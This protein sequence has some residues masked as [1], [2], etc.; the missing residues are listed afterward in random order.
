MEN[1]ES[2]DLG[3]L[4]HIL[5]DRKKTVGKIVGG[6]T[7]L[8]LIVSFALPKTYES[9]T[10]VQAR[11]RGVGVTEASQ[12]MAAMGMG[13]AS[14][15]PVM[16]YMELM[17]SNTVLQP[18]IDELDW[19]EDK[20][21]NLLPKDFAK[22]NLKIENVKQTNIITVTATGKSPEEAQ[23]ISQH[24]V[25]NF[26]QM[27]TD[28][29]KETQSILM[30]FLA[31]RIENAK[32]EAEEARNKF[33]S[34][35]QEHGIYSP[36][37]QAK[38]AVNKMN[39]FDEAIGQMKVSQ[40][41]NQVKIDSVTAKLGE[42]KAKSINFQISDNPTVQGLRDKIVAKQLE[43]VSLRQKYTDENPAVIRAQEQLSQLQQSLTNE[44][45]TVVGSKYATSTP[46]QAAL[47]QEQINAQVAIDVSKASEEAI[48][49]RRDE[50]QKK[51]DAFPQKVQDYM[52]LQRDT[53]IKEEIYSNL[54][55]RF[56]Q[57][58]I[59]QAMDSMDVQVVD[60][61]NL[62][63]VNRPAGP[64]KVLI[65]GI[66]FIIGCLIS[67]GYGLIQYKREEA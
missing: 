20:K 6:C 22:K 23:M 58:R 67:F 18:I 2:L 31:E 15:S 40:T 42:V 16:N 26:L 65:T 55:T 60:S 54:Q 25:D 8:A 36:D 12:A 27:M 37:E 38:A 29:N 19:D 46:A 43:V 49:K 45:N 5:A 56:E 51:L 41:A 13:A 9:T 62:P 30:Q 21:K 63:D 7:A 35:Q 32:K 28:M 61:A 14:T 33:A 59:Q 57:N 11:V 48:E 34:Y 50:K 10:T 17:K 53:K 1:E 3:R 4:M 64:R 52:D 47:I 66:G 44:V 24:V 39:A